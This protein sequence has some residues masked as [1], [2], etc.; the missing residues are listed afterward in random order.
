MSVPEPEKI[1]LAAHRYDS[2]LFYK[3]LDAEAFKL[4][5]YLSRGVYLDQACA[6]VSGQPQ[7]RILIGRL[8]SERDLR[9]GLRSVGF[10]DSAQP[11]RT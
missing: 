3:C 11:K 10:A 7:A 9:R 8:G 6:E 5:S 1:H 4:L 2:L